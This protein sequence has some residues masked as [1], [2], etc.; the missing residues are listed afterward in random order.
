MGFSGLVRSEGVAE[1][2]KSTD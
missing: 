1:I 2:W